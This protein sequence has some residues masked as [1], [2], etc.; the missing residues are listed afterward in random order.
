VDGDA[1]TYADPGGGGD[2]SQ[3]QEEV[4]REVFS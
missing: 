3:L 2:M 1:T 4:L